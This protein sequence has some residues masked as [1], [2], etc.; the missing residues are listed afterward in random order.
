MQGGGCRFEPDRLHFGF[1]RV[2]NSG[3]LENRKKNGCKRLPCE[4]GR[5]TIVNPSKKK[6]KETTER[7]F[8]RLREILKKSLPGR[9]TMFRQLPMI[10]RSQDLKFFKLF[11]GRDLWPIQKFLTRP[12]LMAEHEDRKNFVSVL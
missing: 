4:T 9:L 3:G 1:S 12:Q 10:F 8:D 5:D 6:S 11:A 2:L 7:A